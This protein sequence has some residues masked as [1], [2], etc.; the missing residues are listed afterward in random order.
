MNKKLSFN[1]LTIVPFALWTYI[2][3]GLSRVKNIFPSEQRLNICIISIFVYLIFV[4]YYTLLILHLKKSA[5]D[6]VK[7]RRYCIVCIVIGSVFLMSSL[8]F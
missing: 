1:F 3:F 6:N 8:V 2:A 4:F 7:Y 5:I